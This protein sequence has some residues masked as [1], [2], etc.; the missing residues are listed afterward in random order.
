MTA[1]NPFATE[2]REQVVK[3][4]VNW[5][6]SKQLWSFPKKK[7]FQTIKA[8]C[9]RA[10]YDQNLNSLSNIEVRFPTSTRKL[11]TESA[12]SPS[13]AEYFQPVEAG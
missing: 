5:S 2:S 1:R 7:R 3:S 6:H 11:F 13:P 12:S 10:F 4:I 9:P 8:E